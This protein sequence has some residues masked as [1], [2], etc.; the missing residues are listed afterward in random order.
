MNL[1]SI[2]IILMIIMSGLVGWKRGV[3]KEAV[4]FIGTII[5]FVIAY[6]LKDV[7]GDLLCKYL[8]FFTFSDNLEGV[9]SLNILIYQ[10]LAFA[11]IVGVLYGIFGIIMT[12]TGIMQ[13]IVNMTIILA[14]PSK[15]LGF[16]IGL[17]EGY[18]I[19]FVLLVALAIPLKQI[20]SYAENSLTNKIIYE[21]PILSK[22]IGNVGDAISDIYGLIDSINK[23]HQTTNQINLD[24]IDIMLKYKIVSV[25]E[26]NKL[27]A[28]DK[29]DTINNIESITNKYK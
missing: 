15:I 22:S 5:I 21:S 12:M 2:I 20:P 7:V 8:P 10:T 9:V 29:L 1:F 17:I 13:K 19:V 4:F 16:I 26:I 27:I 24:C 11:L 6:K 3:L 23:K 28:L 18:I 14:L 25:R